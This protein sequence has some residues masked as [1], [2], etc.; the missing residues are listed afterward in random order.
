LIQ[1]IIPTAPD[2]IASIDPSW[3]RHAVPNQAISIIK[4]RLVAGATMK[5]YMLKVIK[6]VSIEKR[7]LFSMDN[8]FIG[9]GMDNLQ[10]G[11]KICIL[12]GLPV[13]MVLRPLG[14]KHRHTVISP[15]LVHG[16]MY[17]EAFGKLNGFTEVELL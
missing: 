6:S 13:P 15:V 9:T 16:L 10:C 4:L 11:D 12:E 5:K 17:R 8:G 14:G 7:C 1:Y 2:R 3:N